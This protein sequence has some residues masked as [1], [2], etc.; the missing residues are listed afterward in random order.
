MPIENASFGNEAEQ[1]N[2]GYGSDFVVDLLCASGMEYVAANPGASI[3]GLYDSLV[4]YTGKHQP[5]LIECCHEEVAVAIAHG[6]AKA[7][8]KPMAA[9]VHNVVGL[10]HAT[11]A[12][13]NAWCDR[14]P[15]LVLGGTGPM[16]VSQRRPWIDWIHTAS[17][18]GAVVRDYVKWSDQPYTIDSIADSYLR[19]YRLAIT[20]PCGPVYLCYDAALQEQKLESFL[21]IPPPAQFMP[22]EP[23]QANPKAL[24]QITDALVRAQQPVIVAD[25]V[26]RNPD[27]VVALVELAEMLGAPVIDRGHRFNF[28]SNHPLDFTGAAKEVLQSADVVLALDVVDLYGALHP[29]SDTDLVNYTPICVLAPECQVIHITM[30]DLFA[31]SWSADYQKFYPVDISVTASTAIALPTLV[32]LCQKNFDLNGDLIRQTRADKFITR[33]RTLRKQWQQTAQSAVDRSPIAVSSAI[34]VIWDAIRHEDWMLTYAGSFRGWVRKLWDIENPT[35]YIGHSG[36][37]GLGYGL[38]ASIGAAL[39]YQGTGKLCINIQ[40]D[41]DL[42]YTCSA[43]WTA[44]H[45]QIPLLVLVFNNQGYHNSLEHGLQVASDRGRPWQNASIGTTLTSPKVDFAT[46][47]RS[48]G[49]YGDGPIATCNELSKALQKALKHIKTERQPA[50]IDILI[51][52]R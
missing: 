44:A 47:T 38:G 31:S 41:G 37:V 2:T 20:D 33:S 11:M 42:L 45:H 10:L 29:A 32:E 21:A 28:P 51:E 14:V 27:A 23:P 12:I 49:V 43:L 7:A 16:D 30:G 17:N 3:R 36:G 4:N 46:L 18:Q 52:P 26:G 40:P 24:K 35:Q 5:K 50:L 25:L 9:L 15:L 6:Y 39:A 22:S 8:G 48:F 13:F 34:T 1:P 19:A